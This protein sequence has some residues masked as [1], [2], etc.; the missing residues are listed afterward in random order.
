MKV[1][2][3]AERGFG[4]VFALLDIW[5]CLVSYQDPIKQA[6]KSDLSSKYNEELGEL[7]SGYSNAGKKRR[8]IKNNWGVAN[9]CFEEFE[10][11]VK[12]DSIKEIPP[13]ATVHQLT[14]NVCVFFKRLYEYRD[15]INDLWKGKSKSPLGEFVSMCLNFISLLKF[16][17]TLFIRVE[18]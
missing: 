15:I 9:K 13:D 17:S 3:N 5:A 6:L 14:S 2:K 4:G 1:K 16:I 12:D 7:I 11:Y 18:K 10:E 8:E